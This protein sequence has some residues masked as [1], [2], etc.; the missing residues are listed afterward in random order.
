MITYLKRLLDERDKLTATQTALSDKAATE[1]V[2]LTKTEESTL[3]TIQT[4]CA[5][6]DAQIAVFNEQAESQRAYA[7]IRAAAEANSEPVVIEQRAADPAV[8]SGA[9]QAEDRQSWIEPFLR[10]AELANYSGHGQS[11]RVETGSMLAE[12]RAAGP[13]M[14]TTLPAGAVQPFRW[15]GNVQTPLQI[16]PLLALCTTVTVNA[17]AVDYLYVTPAPATK[18]PE[19]AEGALKPEADLTIN[20]LSQTLKTFAHWKAAT[21]QALDDI[22]QLQQLLENYLRAGVQMAV[23]GGIVDAL[24]ADANIEAVTGDSMLAA[25]RIGMATVQGNHRTPNGIVLNPLDWADIDLSALAAS[26]SGAVVQNSPW[27]LTIAAAPDL[28]QGT[29]YVGD[30]R[31]G[32]TVFDRGVSNTYATDSHAD[33]FL[34]NTIVVLAETRALPVVT[35]TPSLVKISSTETMQASAP[36]SAPASSGS[37]GK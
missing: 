37:G 13:I 11:G 9:A 33:F 15:T 28:P 35:D 1:G 12:T 34:K 16:T 32:V 20:L 29:G 3:A 14:T 26:M 22:A 24:A 5:E 4:R 25:A 10:S 17:G 6:L 31:N 21:R 8:Q 7:K 23:E 18:A 27:G 2:D 36:Q 19:V 30:F